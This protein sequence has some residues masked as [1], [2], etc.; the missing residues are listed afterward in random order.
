[1]EAY[2]VTFF[3]YFFDIKFNFASPACSN[4][5]KLVIEMIVLSKK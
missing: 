2:P 4:S 1:M 3:D 5:F